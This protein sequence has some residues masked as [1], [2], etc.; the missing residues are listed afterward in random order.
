MSKDTLTVAVVT[1]VFPRE[2]TWPELRKLLE[3][4]RNDG[5]QLAVLPEIPG[6]ESYHFLMTWSEPERKLSIYLNGTPLRP[7]DAP[8]HRR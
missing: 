4:A 3:E 6:P 1:R 8:V 2:G 5:A 7:P